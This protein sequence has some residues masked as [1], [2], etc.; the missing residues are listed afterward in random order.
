V[1]LY[2]LVLLIAIAACGKAN[3]LPAMKEEAGGLV[4]N[5]QA[6][7]EELATRAT[8]IE[9][10]GN[11]I[12]VTTPDAREASQLYARAKARLE[13]LRA[14]LRNAKAEIDPIKDRMQMRRWLDDSERKLEDGFTEI[15][16]DF[17]A[18]E[19]WLTIH[20]GGQRGQ[21]SRAP[22]PVVPP[23]TGQPA[24]TGAGGTTPVQ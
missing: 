15:N 1:K 10:R 22:A 16:A 23:P 24:Q 17:N 11:A 5:Y 3:D 2:T 8:S 14:D 6:R 4:K 19:S 20:E 9:Q 13:K 12:G 7:F 21:V 18:V